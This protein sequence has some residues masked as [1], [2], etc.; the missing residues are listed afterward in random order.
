M[1]TPFFAPPSPLRGSIAAQRAALQNLSL[2]GLG[3]R[4]P[5]VR[6]VR[7]ADSGPF[8]S[9][10]YDSNL[11]GQDTAL[12]N[13]YNQASRE[14]EFEREQDAEMRRERLERERMAQDRE[15]SLARIAADSDRLNAI[16]GRSG[17]GRSGRGGGLR[18]YGTSPTG[19]VQDY[20][21]MLARLLPS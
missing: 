17:G 14:V 4:R 11:A 6:S 13:T 9:L 21:S 5:G 15:L 7:T 1:A 20:R 16:L 10:T 3:N 8:G 2:A 12:I 19:A 18:G